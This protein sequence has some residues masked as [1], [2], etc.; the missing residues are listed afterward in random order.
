MSILLYI[1]VSFV[2]SSAS[3]TYCYTD[4]RTYRDTY[5]YVDARTRV[6]RVRAT[7]AHAI[8]ILR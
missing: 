3:N 2:P 4:A 1:D 7:S 8:E 6:P 5:T